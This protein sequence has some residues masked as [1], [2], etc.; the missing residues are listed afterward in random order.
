MI[1]RIFTFNKS[2]IFLQAQKKQTTTKN[3]HLSKNLQT[4]IHLV[5]HNK[6]THSIFE[7]AKI[8]KSKDNLIINHY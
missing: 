7:W 3:K 4:A 6:Q 5:N 2:N 8:D 1:R